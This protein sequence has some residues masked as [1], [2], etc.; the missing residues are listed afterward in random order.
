MVLK[1]LVID[2]NKNRHSNFSTKKYGSEWWKIIVWTKWVYDFSN[3]QSIFEGR[4]IWVGSFVHFFKSGILFLKIMK[5]W[6]NDGHGAY[7]YYSAQLAK[8]IDGLLRE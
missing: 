5:K 3:E 7:T 2:E 6:L 4:E 1:I 8:E